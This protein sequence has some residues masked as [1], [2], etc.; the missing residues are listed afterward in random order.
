MSN[1]H[2]NDPGSQGLEQ[3]KFELEAEKWRYQKEWREK[4]FEIEAKKLQQAKRD[5]I[6]RGFISSL[7]GTIIVVS[8]PASLTLYARKAEEQKTIRAEAQRKQ[9]TLIQLVNSRE[10]ADSNLR[11][12]MFNALLQNYFKERDF[13][14]QIAILEII[15]L[16]FRDS[17]HTKPMFERLRANI[18]EKDADNASELL[19]AL[20]RASQRIIRDQLQQIKQSKEGDVCEIEFSTDSISDT[21]QNPTCFQDLAVRLIELKDDRIVVQTNSKDQRLLDTSGNMDDGDEFGVSFYD[22]PMVDYTIVSNYGTTWKYS[23]VLKDIDRNEHIVTI[24]IANLPE[25]TFGTSE[26]YKFDEML[27]KYLTE[28]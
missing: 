18:V 8:I 5:T 28:S 27:R 24:A 3:K 19:E 4:E 26:E 9:E 6:L 13:R 7:L 25:D 20:R 1:I 2:E 15:G 12:Q 14:T 16:N 11:A 17:L 21:P 23:I 10:S 22:M